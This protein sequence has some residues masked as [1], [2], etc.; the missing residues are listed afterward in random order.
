MPIFPTLDFQ[1]VDTYNNRM[2]NQPDA[3]LLVDIAIGFV[4]P[5]VKGASII[6]KI[7]VKYGLMHSMESGL[8]QLAEEYYNT[9]IVLTNSDMRKLSSINKEFLQNKL[10][11]SEFFNQ[12]S[13]SCDRVCD[14][15]S[16]MS[17]DEYEMR[18]K[19]AIKNMESLIRQAN[20][21]NAGYAAD[22]QILHERS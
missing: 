12:H 10:V 14:T 19:N 17:D 8:K 15:K 9:F 5:F 7:A 1:Q 11:V 16:E 4:S 22:Y 3:F 6:T 18:K 21:L 13:Q 20:I 2:R